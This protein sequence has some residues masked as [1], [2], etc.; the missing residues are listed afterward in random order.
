MIGGGVLNE[1]NLKSDSELVDYEQLNDEEK[2][3][4]L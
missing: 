1:D 2:L 4:L 3:M